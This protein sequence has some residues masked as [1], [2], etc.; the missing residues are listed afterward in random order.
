[1]VQDFSSIFWWILNRCL[2]INPHYLR[3]NGSPSYHQSRSAWENALD[4]QAGRL[5]SPLPGAWLINPWGSWHSGQN[6][7]EKIRHLLGKR[8]SCV[9][10]CP[11][12]AWIAPVRFNFPLQVT[13]RRHVLRF[14]G[15]KIIFDGKAS[16]SRI[17]F[18][19]SN[20]ELKF[21]TV[22]IIKQHSLT[23]RMM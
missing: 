15:C 9:G 18:Y 17:P 4:T 8:S 10:I 5:T 16:I 19:N 22:F 23:K 2:Q 6:Q 3:S 1:M 20:F 7:R 14:K 12:H 13:V 21:S 11:N